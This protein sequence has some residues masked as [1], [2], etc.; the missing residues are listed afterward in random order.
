MA[1]AVLVLAP[2]AI[3]PAFQWHPGLSAKAP[4]VEVDLLARWAG[5]LC[6][7]VGL[8]HAP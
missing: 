3:N 1:K 5:S 4:P 7:L 2:L 8:S 6:G